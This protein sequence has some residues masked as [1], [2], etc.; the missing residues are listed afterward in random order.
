MTKIK[1]FFKHPQ[2]ARALRIFAFAFGAAVFGLFHDHALTWQ[3]IGA[4]AI[5]AAEV[6]FRMFF[7]TQPK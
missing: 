5:A 6:V 2:V 7:P 4:A 1:A 3:A